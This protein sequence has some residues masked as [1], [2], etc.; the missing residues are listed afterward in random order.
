MYAAEG[1][2]FQIVQML[3]SAERIEFNA[4]DEVIGQQ[5]MVYS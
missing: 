5:R 1:G 2:A 3:L 4:A